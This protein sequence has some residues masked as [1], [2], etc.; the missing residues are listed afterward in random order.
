MIKGGEGQ[1]TWQ[2]QPKMVESGKPETGKLLGNMD[3]AD[4]VLT[5]QALWLTGLPLGAQPA[6]QSHQR[7]SLT[8]RRSH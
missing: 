1:A 2:G 6:S 7:F 8:K 3:K 5:H 4:L